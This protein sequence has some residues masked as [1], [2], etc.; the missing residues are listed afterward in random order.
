MPDYSAE[1]RAMKQHQ[2]LVAGVDEAGRGPWA[3]PVVAAA[4]AFS[5]A[6]VIPAGLN[7][8]KKLSEAKR[9]A[10]FEKLMTLAG[11]GDVMSG[12]G[13]VSVE[14][15]DRMNI[16]A[17]SLYAMSVAVGKLA[18]VPCFLLVDGNKLPPVDMPAEA[19]VKGDGRS[20][21]IAAASIIAKVTRDRLMT[22]LGEAYPQYQWGRNKGYGTKAHRE[23]LA[24]HGVS[25]HHRRSFKPIRVLIEG[26]TACNRAVKVNLRKK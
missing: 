17:A 22:E 8:S 6:G 9:E 13:V 23:G 15:I 11:G 1:L 4:V 20:L 3:G 16:L 7:D 25:P 26:E 5:D 24:T 18:G 14:D 2:G 10:L 21:S 19:L 12:V